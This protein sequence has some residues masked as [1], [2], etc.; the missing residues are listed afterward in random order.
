M[1][2]I[3]EKLNDIHIIINLS[4]EETK[5]HIMEKLNE[6]LEEI[7]QN[8]DSVKNKLLQL[9]L[10]NNELATNIAQSIDINDTHA[11]DTEISD[12]E[13]S[14]KRQQIIEKATFSYYWIFKE[15][16]NQMNNEELFDTEEKINSGKWFERE[17]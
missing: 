6:Q 4:D 14:D 5:K 12:T 10:Y 7:S 3:L 15:R 2:L 8:I 1:D 13:I 17:S 11:S 16:I 9:S